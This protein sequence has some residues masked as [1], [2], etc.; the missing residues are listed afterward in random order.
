MGAFEYETYGG[1]YG[2]DDVIDEFT[3]TAPA[4]IS[5]VSGENTD[6]VR[7]NDYVDD[8]PGVEL[9]SGVWNHEQLWLPSALNSTLATSHSVTLTG[10]AA[11]TTYFYQVQSQSAQGGLGISG[12]FMLHDGGGGPQPLLQMHL[13][14]T[15]VSG[16]TNGS[17][18]T[19]SIAPAGFTGAVVANGTGSVN[20]TAGRRERSLLP[21]L[22]REHEQ[23][24]LQVHGHDDR[25]YLHLDRGRSRSI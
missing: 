4:G 7:S 15:E 11:S 21:E 24:I 23:R 18:V 3:V 9:A 17:A 25:Q 6:F 10:L 22:L 12:G 1:F 14:R 20:F 5:A 2:L 8:G 19:P 16:V 13:D